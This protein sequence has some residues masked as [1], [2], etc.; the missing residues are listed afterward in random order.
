MNKLIKIV[1]LQFKECSQEP[2]NF[3]LI[4]IV[5]F[6]F[7]KDIVDFLMSGHRIFL[8][9]ILILPIL[10]MMHPIVIPILLINIAL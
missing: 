7:S 2:A 4:V 6:H 10:V 1:E 3:L 8:V 9:P 5:I